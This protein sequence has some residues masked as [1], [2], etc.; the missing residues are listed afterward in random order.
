MS[1][2]PLYQVGKLLGRS[3]SHAQCEHAARTLI[4]DGVLYHTIVDGVL[5]HT[6]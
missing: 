6:T 4:M 2:V 5:Y 1:E 3:V